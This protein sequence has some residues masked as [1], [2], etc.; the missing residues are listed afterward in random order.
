MKRIFIAAGLLVAYMAASA[1]KGNDSTVYKK[2]QISRTDIQALFSYYTQD[3]NHSAVTGGKGTEALQVFVSDITVTKQR[4]SITTMQLEAGVDVITSA[5]T[6]NIDYV[7]SS[8]SRED[9]RFHIAG[10]YSRLLK[11]SNIRAGINVGFSIESDYLSIP[12]GISVSHDNK[13]HTRQVSA[14][15]Q[16]YFDDLRWGRFDPD[17]YK[18][19]TLVYPVEMRYKQWFDIYR[20]QSYNLSFALNQVINQRMQLAIYPELVYQTG[21]LSTPFHRVYF[22]DGITLKV[23]NL[24][25]TRWKVPLAAQLNTFI[26]SRVILRSYYR[27][28][29]DNFGITGH[30][31]Q[32]ELPVKTG[33]LF[34]LTPLVR[35]YTQSSSK[36]FKPIIQHKVAEEYYTSDYD[37]SRFTS[38]KL[39]MTGRYALFKPI[40]RRSTFQEIGLRYTYYKRSDQLSAHMISLLLDFRHNK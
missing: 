2:Q 32:F 1:Q 8:A 38:Y 17:Y 12:V 5:S 7:L 36:Y 14:S 40:F 25:R 21:L 37:L 10:A 23:E 30:T 9:K 20:R 31:L 11:K 16:C 4:D 34:T 15:L 22:S 29:K 35:L 39:G 33:P 27:F 13:T 18:P 19:E 26:G 3:G 28:Y 6:D 24:P